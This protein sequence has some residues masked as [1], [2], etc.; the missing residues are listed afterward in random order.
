MTS[1][2][3]PKLM[4]SVAFCGMATLVSMQPDGRPFSIRQ[5]QY[6]EPG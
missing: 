1:L 6:D 4:R 2:I 5:R 3:F